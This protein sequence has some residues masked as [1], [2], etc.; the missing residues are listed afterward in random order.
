MSNFKGNKN[1]KGFYRQMAEILKKN[2][3]ISKTIFYFKRIKLPWLNQISFYEFLKLYI[4]GIINGAIS[5]RAAAIAFSFFMAL[6][7]FTLFILNLIPYIPI[8]GFR[9][10]FLDFVAQSV[11]PNTF[12][13]IS[14]TI[15]DILNHSYNGLLSTGFLMSLLLMTNGLNAILGGFETSEHIVIKRGFFHQYFVALG[16]SIILSFLLLFTVAAIVTFEV[17][18]QQT[19]IQDVLSDSIS[20]I[21]MGRLIFVVIMILITTSIL[22]KFG[23]KDTKG[24]S[25]ISVASV[26][27]TLLVLLSF[28]FFGIWVVKFSKYNQLYGSIGTLLIIMF[29]IWI[30]C[31]VLLV[32]FELNALINKLKKIDS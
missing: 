16:M 22:F 5:Y 17:L 27:T 12:G 9:Q 1:I 6:F 24:S 30:N 2:T 28:Y 3:L 4:I 21:E 14:A 10:D 20:L 18:I 7:P 31:M 8:S 15:T 32:G 29:F 19:K 23:T 11:P 25:F 13:A 26:F